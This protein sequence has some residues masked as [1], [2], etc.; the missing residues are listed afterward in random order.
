[1]TATA[2][3][4]REEAGSD[5]GQSS[6][7]VK[8]AYIN[9][10]EDI[11]VTNLFKA[12]LEEKGYK[13]QMQQ[14]EVGPLY[15]GL[16]KGDAD[17]FLDAWLPA[18]HADYWAKYKNDME[19]LGVWYDQATLNI[20]VPSYVNDVN[21]L[22]DLKGKA[23]QFGGAITGIDP[24]AGLTRTTKDEV[25]PQ[26]GLGGEYQLKTSSESAMLA[27]LKGAIADKKPIVVTSWHP[28]WMYNRYDLKDLKDP[29]GA[30]GEAEQIHSLG[31]KGFSKDFPELTKMVKQFKMDDAKLASLSD[32]INQAGEGNELKAAKDWAKQN[33]QYVDQLTSPIAG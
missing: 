8:I 5:T 24:G 28:H 9:W 33:K 27:A 25:I 13:V 16:A 15:A 1:M 2:C 10:A 21:S 14:L 32:A 20:A 11:A 12:A 30:L 4:S 26:Y 23:G 7:T 3:G 31:R 29:K 22:A 6:K 19:D 18:T 17:L